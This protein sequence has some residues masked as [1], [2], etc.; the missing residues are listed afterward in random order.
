MRDNKN[1][2]M[3]GLVG[4][5]ALILVPMYV[6]WPKAEA[7]LDD[8]WSHVPS[9]PVHTDH[10]YLLEG[11]FE[12]GPE[13]TAACLECHEDAAHEVGQTEHWN[14]VGEPV[15][16]PGHDEPVAIGKANLL[17]NFCIGVQSNWEGCTACHA[18]YGWE[19]E[20][21]DFSNTANVDCLVC[22]DGSG[23]YG[24]GKA[25][26][27]LEGVDL[28]AVAKSVGAPTRQNCGSC[29]FNGG[30][31]NAVKHG[32]LDTSLYFPSE[33]I[34]VHMGRLDFQCTDCHQTED[35]DISGRSI[36]V[37]V[38]TENQV[39]CIDCHEAEP[40][41]DARL[42]THTETVACQT[43]HIPEGAVRDATKMNWDWS[44]AGNDWPEDT[45]EYLKIKGSFIYESNFTPD[46]LWYNGTAERYLLGDVMD[47]STI[48]PINFPLG[49]I[50]DASSK[51]WPFKIHYAKQPYDLD[52]SYLLQP[53]TV[54]EGGYWTDFDWDQALRLAEEVT[55]IPYSGNY[56]FADTSMYWP[57]SHM[58]APAEQALQCTA[59]H[60]DN[61]RLDW[62]AL[63]YP[64][65]PMEW[66]GRED[67]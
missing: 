66:G 67:N 59:C 19:D 39:A 51:I 63:G 4:T 56:G 57:L 3:F 58:V 16:V 1:I 7:P 47:A 54:G 23:T 49:E 41:L 30:G 43:C 33:D 28:L 64:G 36:S 10:S 14:W 24:K 38:E 8:P 26:Q 25:G 21:Y 42:N 31:G 6:F 37:S 17:N 29:H 45:H 60:G 62:L 22:H 12:T 13:V 61:G 50:K 65:D 27:P 35:H 48:T 20:N 5:L 52:F 53:K 40:H 2:W 46:Y 15:Q 34:D 11:P 9:R 44:T 32:D 55:G 18:G